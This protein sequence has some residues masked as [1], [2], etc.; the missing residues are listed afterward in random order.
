MAVLTNPTDLARET[1]KLLAARRIAPTPE[2][3]TRY[4]HEIAG[5]AAP[6]DDPYDR[7]AEAVR[8]VADANPALTAL[9]RIARTLEERDLA[10]F[11]AALA[12]LASGREAGVRH[13]WGGV[14]RE[15]VRLLGARQT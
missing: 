8:Q 12:A 13:D 10:Q 11:T 14:L 1:L 4:Y 6:G 7:L 15:L 3:F 9:A 5:T 2:N